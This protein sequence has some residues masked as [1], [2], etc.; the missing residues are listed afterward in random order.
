MVQ[1]L[2][3]SLQVKGASI[4]TCEESNINALSGVMGFFEKTFFKEHYFVYNAF[5]IDCKTNDAKSS[6]AICVG[7]AHPPIPD[8]SSSSSF[9]YLSLVDISKGNI[10]QKFGLRK[11]QVDDPC[12]RE[13]NGLIPRKQLDILVSSE[14]TGYSCFLL[15]A[16]RTEALT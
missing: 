3:A 8:Y 10:T 16:T 2:C 9:H 13:R 5:P 14:T 1:T 15:W 7:R 12:R 4:F 6:I 11:E